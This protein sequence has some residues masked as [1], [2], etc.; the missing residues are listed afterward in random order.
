MDFATWHLLL[1]PNCQVYEPKVDILVVNSP[2]LIL[3]DTILITTSTVKQLEHHVFE[4]AV[5]NHTVKL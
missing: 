3:L 4:M 1:S 2:S 5:R